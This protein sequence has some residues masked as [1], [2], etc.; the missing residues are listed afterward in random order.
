M[1]VVLLLVVVL[2]VVVVVFVV[3]PVA[4]LVFVV[5]VLMVVEVMVVVMVNGHCEQPLQYQFLHA[6][7]HPP[8]MVLHAVGKHCPAVDVD[9]LAFPTVVLV[10]DDVVVYEHCGHDPQ[11]H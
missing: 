7:S 5:V 10:V 8:C 1:V 9:V 3:L 4:V 2:P 6:T 11:N